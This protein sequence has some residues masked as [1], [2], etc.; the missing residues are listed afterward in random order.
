MSVLSKDTRVEA[1]MMAAASSVTVNSNGESTF[2]CPTD[3]VTYGGNL[4]YLTGAPSKLQLRNFNRVRDGSQNLVHVN[5]VTIDNEAS[6]T[7]GSAG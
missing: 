1:T 4:L 3:G 2:L 6:W 7:A 5:I